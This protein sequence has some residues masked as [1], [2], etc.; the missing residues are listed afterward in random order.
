M[1]KAAVVKA[2]SDVRAALAVLHAEV[3]E[4][5]AVPF[6]EVDPLA[7]LGDG[8]L[9]ILAV[10]REAEA[11]FAW[12]KARAAA[13][14]AE[15]AYAAAPPDAPV[16]AL[17]MAVAAEIGA[18]L[19]LGSR[20][21]GAFLSASHAL[22]GELPLTVSAL[23]DGAITWQHALVMVDE[24]V[25]LDRAGAAALEAQFLDPDVPRPATAA[26]VGE[27]PAY[28][29]RARARTWRERH[30]AASIEKRHA[31]GVADRRV[32]FRPEPDGMASLSAYLP[33]GQATAVWNRL[34]AAGRGLQ[35]P[36]AGR[37]LTQLRADLYAGWLLGG[38]T[39]P[40]TA[41]PE[42]TSPGATSPGASH[43][44]GDVTGPGTDGRL[45]EVRAQVLVTV[46][47]FSLLG[48]TEEPAVLDG[49]GPIPPS[50]ARQLV[51]NGA[52]SFYRVLVDPRDGAP[53]EIG[54]TSYR[55]TR[56]MKK[57]LQLRDGKCTF[58]GCS[59]AS[60]DNEADHLTAWQHGGTTGISNLA[61]LCPKHH[62]LKHNSGWT[63]DPATKNAPPGWTSPTGRHYKAEHHDWE[64]P[65]WPHHL[66]SGT[67]E[68]AGSPP[69]FIYARLSPG[70]EALQSRT[71]RLGTTPLAP[72]PSVRD[73]GNRRQPSGLHLRQALPGRRGIRA[74][75]ARPTRLT[76]RTP[77]PSEA[78]TSRLR[79]STGSPAVP[80]FR[81]AHPP[82]LGLDGL[83]HRAL[84]FDRLTH[85]APGF[86]RLNHRLWGF[87]RLTHRL[88][89][90]TGSPCPGFDLVTHGFSGRQAQPPALGLGALTHPATATRGHSPHVAVVVMSLL[91]PS[92]KIARGL[93]PPWQAPVPPK[94][95]P[96]RRPHHAG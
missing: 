88:W 42:T 45:S 22:V 23:Q 62:R 70:E 75:P 79:D 12:L 59:N 44:A 58:P 21:A 54:R 26:L 80:G 24:A 1:G 46:P 83:T 92:C 27:M 81:R 33:A 3:V 9:D 30:H 14:Y 71:P 91:A 13:A 2:R 25:G 6:S 28:R 36:G 38:T 50:M 37:T 96:R 78:P 34:T 90:S 67:V 60:L 31:R 51:A 5:G 18:L 56:A 19:S 89:V 43:G 29:F 11:G 10:A 17:E 35:G 15:T 63:P 66:Q 68:T 74:V 57:T 48:L 4:R 85:R 39:R 87:D 49:Y 41:A 95:P 86:V 55:L 93:A 47:V 7:G 32:E 61:Q 64:P 72:P 94:K 84:G 77:A 40:A 65:H 69:D 73:R 76:N 20:A 8:C 52:T 53:L 82:A 16:Q